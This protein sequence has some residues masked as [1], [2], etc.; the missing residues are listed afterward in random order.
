MTT[1]GNGPQAA[2]D[3]IEELEDTFL[4]CRDISHAWTAHNVVI[5]RRQRII[6]AR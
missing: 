1:N 5:G 2:P 4:V 6:T 3:S